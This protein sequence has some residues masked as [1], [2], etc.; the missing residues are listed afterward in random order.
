[1]NMKLLLSIGLFT[2]V[3]CKSWEFVGTPIPPGTN[4]PKN[5][6]TNNP[7]YSQITAGQQGIEDSGI[8]QVPNVYVPRPGARALNNIGISN[9]AENMGPSYRPQYQQ[10]IGLDQP[11]DLV[12]ITPMTPDNPMP[13]PLEKRYKQ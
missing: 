10:A 2:F 8:I 5:L 13:Y 3:T 7:G 12:P 6:Y 11:A 1:M 9:E 4:Q